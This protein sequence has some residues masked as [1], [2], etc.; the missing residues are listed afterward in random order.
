MKHEIILNTLQRDIRQ[1]LIKRASEGGFYTYKELDKDLGCPY[2][3]LKNSSL[4]RQIVADLGDVSR[5]EMENGRPLLSAIVVRKGMFEP[6]T[7]FYKMAN[8][9]GKL[10]NDADRVKFAK[11]EQRKVHD[12][13]K[14]YIDEPHDDMTKENRFNEKDIDTPFPMAA[15]NEVEPVEENIPNNN[16]ENRFFKD[17]LNDP[18][19]YERGVPYLLHQKDGSTIISRTAKDINEGKINPYKT[20]WMSVT[21]YLIPF[22][23]ELLEL[24]DSEFID[25]VS[26][27][28]ED[29]LNRHK[30]ED[31]R[32]TQV[33]SGYYGTGKLDRWKYTYLSDWFDYNISIAKTISQEIL[34]NRKKAD[35]YQKKLERLKEN[36]DSQKEI[37]SQE[38][39]SNSHSAPEPLLRE[40]VDLKAQVEQLKREKTTLEKRNNELEATNASLEILQEQ[41]E[42]EKAYN[43]QTG[44]KCFTS[45]QMGILMQAVGIKTEEPAPGKTTLGEVVEKISG[46]NATTF[47]QNMK[48]AHRE[49]DKEVVA[50]AI[51]SKF[52]N[53]AAKIRNL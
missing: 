49:A 41:K 4:T 11:N 46:Y 34:D 48:G 45:T 15:K 30:H 19:T 28:I 23:R 27:A 22:I 37:R 18:N 25:E 53:L 17:I 26:Q 32:Y 9:I 20:N 42:P 29:E 3:G 7:G 16:Q 47:T 13:W 31:G 52:P 44:K 24:I 10:I 5:Y 50:K 51:E 40:I 36:K 43:V 33:L 35:E 12:Y 39:S 21:L 2:D 38:T 6:G 14:K 8:E 1:K